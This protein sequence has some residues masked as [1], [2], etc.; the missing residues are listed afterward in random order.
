[1]FGEELETAPLKA[2]LPTEAKLL[3]APD[4]PLFEFA[5]EPVSEDSVL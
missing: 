2:T 3:V 1:M 4:E 5:F